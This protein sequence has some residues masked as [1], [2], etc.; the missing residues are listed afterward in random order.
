[1]PTIVNSGTFGFAD[2]N[3]GHVCDLGSAPSVGQ[4]DILCVNSDTVVAT[5]SGFTAGPTAVFG[6]GAYI[7]R[8]KAAGGEA[9]TVTITTTGNFNTHVVW[10]RVASANAADVTG[11]AHADGS[12]NTATPAFT[13]SALA[14]SGELAVAFAALHS[15]GAA[16][17]ATPVWSTGYTALAGGSQNTSGGAVGAFVGT[18]TPAGTAAETP[19]VSWTGN[20]S[21]RYILFL[22]LTSSADPVNGTLAATLPPLTASLTGVESIPGALAA[23]L[24]MLTG[25]AAGV[26]SIPGALAATLPMLLGTGAGVEEITGTLAATLPLLA[27]AIA[28][29]T[30]TAGS[31]LNLAAVMQEIADR[32]DTIPGLRVYGWPV[33][34]LK[35]PAAVVLYPTRIVYDETADRGMDSFELGVFVV[36]GKA[37]L[38]STRDRIGVYANSDGSRSIKQVLETGE[39]TTCDELRV[40][41]ATFDAVTIGGT[42]YMAGL[43]DLELAGSGGG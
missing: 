24:P 4:F 26:E 18:K 29:E 9:S 3:S 34:S 10:L 35:P 7:F 20:V 15:T 6:Q 2:G 23:T 22:S 11:E 37:D 8:R 41:E 33:G 16:A 27:A 13:S 36:V 19:S 42:E 21:D 32:L 14:E 43:F 30:E 31:G 40:Q 28:A 17:A 38:K 39:Y 1:M 25:S 12:A 5:P